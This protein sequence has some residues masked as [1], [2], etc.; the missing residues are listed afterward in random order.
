MKKVHITLQG[1]GGIG[2]SYVASLIAQYHLD[3]HIPVTCLDADPVNSTLSTYPRLAAERLKL[4][5]DDTMAEHLDLMRDQIVSADRDIVLDI[6]SVAFLPLSNYLIEQG[7]IYALTASK[8]VM[9]HV[10]LVGGQAMT[11]TINGLTN[12]ITCLPMEVRIVAW[13]NEY[14]GPIRSDDAHFERMPVYESC[15]ERLFGTARLPCHTSST[16]SADVREML[17]RRLTF[18]EAVADERFYLTSRQR[19]LNVK[20][21]IFSSLEVIP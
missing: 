18:Q 14:F 1:K 6:G 10:V 2:K 20:R 16:V 4:T 17:R 7:A 8:T 5:S 12:L 11:D 13:L 3:R 21:E 9:M 19:L 15:R